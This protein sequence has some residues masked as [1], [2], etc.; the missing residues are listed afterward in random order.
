MWKIPEE[1]SNNNNNNNVIH[2]KLCKKFKFDPTNKWYMLNPA[3]VLENETHKILWDFEIQTDHLIL[4]RQPDLL[5]IPP[6]PQ[7]NCR[8][9]DFAVLADHRV[10]LKESIKKQISTSTLLEN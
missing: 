10:K 6:P 4:T 9:E 5:I 1:W 2:G 8:I 7:K 3:S